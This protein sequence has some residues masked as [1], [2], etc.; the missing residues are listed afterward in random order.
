[1][2]SVYGVFDRHLP[3][4]NNRWCVGNRIQGLGTLL[5]HALQANNF[6]NA[7]TP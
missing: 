4:R 3:G 7:K 1:M 6:A 5:T 2:Y